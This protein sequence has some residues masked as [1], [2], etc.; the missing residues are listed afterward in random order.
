LIVG[1]SRI[2]SRE[3]EPSEK[4]LAKVRAM[5][6]LDTPT[7]E[8]REVLWTGILGAAKHL[9]KREWRPTKRQSAVVQLRK[10]AG[11]TPVYFIGMG[12]VELHLAQLICSERSIFGIEIP[13]PSAWRNAAAKN[14]IDAL[15]TMDQ[16][17][18]P[19]VAALSVHAGSSPCVLVG[20]SFNGLMAFHA[21]HQLNEQG[22]KVELVV[23]LDTETKDPAPHQVAWQQ[24]Q[25]DWGRAPDLLL[26][27]R[28]LRSISSRLRSSLSVIRWM[29]VEEMKELGHR[30]L[31][32]RGVLTTK[33]DDL[34]IPWHWKLTMRVYS[35]VLK[36][37][38]LRCLDCRGVLFRS[39]E[40]ES[41]ARTLDDNLGWNNQ[42]KRGLEIVQ[43]TGNHVTM[44]REPHDR[45]LAQEISKAL[46]RHGNTT[47]GF[48]R[49]GNLAAIYID[50]VRAPDQCRPAAGPASG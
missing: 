41:P 24:L 27:D 4:A 42:F 18:A 15:P 35:N 14:D 25:K 50:S 5:K 46:D 7:N 9:G 30:I 21:A 40:D 16:L 11:E 10:G 39:V 43:I 13:W 36:S 49:S 8:A 3:V 12:V 45:M 22:G 44:T 23:L 29:L 32:D 47:P 26:A 31:R 34:G 20:V 6:P 48:E 38:R 33:L 37:Y 1:E 19:Y 28:A 2:S 17:V